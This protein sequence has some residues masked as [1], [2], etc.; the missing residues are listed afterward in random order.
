MNA[1][2]RWLLTGITLTG[3]ALGAGAAPP[4]DVVTTL[5]PLYDWARIVGGDAVRVTLLLPPGVEAHSFSPRPSDIL[6]LNRARAL[7][8]VNNDMEPWLSDLLRGARNPRLRVIAAGEGLADDTAPCP[9]CAT[10]HDHDHPHGG[11]PHVWLDPRL[12]EKMVARIA[13]G[14]AQDFPESAAAFRARAAAYNEQLRALDERIAAGLK[15]CPRREILYGGHFAFGHFA[16]RYGLTHLS[17]YAGFSPN[18]QPRPQQLAELIE[19]M[20]HSGQRVI[21]HEE[22]LDP[23]LARVIAGETGAR[24]EVLHGLHNLTADEWR[25]GEMSYLSVMDDNLRKLRAA[26]REP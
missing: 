14:L 23:R 19:K 5:F 1:L 26:L 6:R 3:W 20:K 10:A 25:R 7:I 15:D 8:H 2:R 17:P 9:G 21:F 12:A 22:L 16:R 24:L 11:D 13:E 4:A 18:A